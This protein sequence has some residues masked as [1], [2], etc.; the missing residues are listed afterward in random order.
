M[1]IVNYSLIAVTALII[2]LVLKE[3]LSAESDNNK[4]MKSFA[5]GSNIAIVPLVL[6]F[7]IVVAYKVMINIG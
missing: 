1:D 6:I 2:F 5:K 7:A 4:R 3:I